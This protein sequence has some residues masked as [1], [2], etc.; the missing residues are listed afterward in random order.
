MQMSKFTA[1]TTH[2]SQSSVLDASAAGLALVQGSK[3]SIDTADLLGWGKGTVHNVRERTNGLTLWSAMQAAERTD[4]AFLIP[5][6]DLLGK[7]LVDRDTPAATCDAGKISPL[8]DEVAAL[9]KF[10]APASDGG[11]ELTDAELVAMAD[12]VADLGI[13]FR[14]LDARLTAARG[15]KLRVAS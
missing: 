1:S 4:G 13:V 8:A 14:E 11:A 9:A 6:L 12:H 3:N 7:T 10:T 5:L 15:A 2:L